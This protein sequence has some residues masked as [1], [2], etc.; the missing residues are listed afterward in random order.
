M[1]NSKSNSRNKATTKASE[2]TEKSYKMDKAILGLARIQDFVKITG[3]TKLFTSLYFVLY[4][5]L[6]PTRNL[7]H[8][9]CAKEGIIHVTWKLVRNTE[10]EHPKPSFLYRIKICI[11]M[12][13]H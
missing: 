1:S 2:R 8:P 5:C 11:L 10:S 4:V 9:A 3:T 7:C 6:G 13:L 12:N